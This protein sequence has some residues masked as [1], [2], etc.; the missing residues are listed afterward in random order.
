MLTAGFL[1]QQGLL[2]LHW[3]ITASV[4][5]SFLTYQ[6]FFLLGRTRGR[7]VLARRPG[8]QLRMA[9]IRDLLERH[10]LLIILGYRALFGLRA[11]TPFALGM[12]GI[13]YLRFTLLDLVPA[14]IWGL[15][16]SLLGFALG[17][18]AEKLLGN[19]EDYQFWLAGAAVLIGLLVVGMYTRY[20]MHSP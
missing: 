12:T 14:L 9:R 6:F 17:K 20:R 10:D 18:G 7:A 8:W 2:E 1:A 4:I 13:S 5:G 19:L 16:I 15:G 3:V 11:L